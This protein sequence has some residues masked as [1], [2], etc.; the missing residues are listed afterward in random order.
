MKR[1]R[2]Q[3][4]SGSVESLYTLTDAHRTFALNPLIQWAYTNAAQMLHCPKQ[5]GGFL[6]RQLPEV[7]GNHIGGGT[8]MTQKKFIRSMRLAF[9]VAALATPGA[10]ATIPM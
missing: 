8:N 10:L 5:R 1:P 2:V 4:R 7:S 3:S 6:G 9:L